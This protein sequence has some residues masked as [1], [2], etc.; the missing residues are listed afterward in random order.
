MKCTDEKT[1]VETWA[2][3]GYFKMCYYDH[4]QTDISVVKEGGQENVCS[5][6]TYYFVS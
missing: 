2:I 4:E 1:E 6:M 3:D 5:K